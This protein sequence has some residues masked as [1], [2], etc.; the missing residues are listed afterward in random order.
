M[1]IL[2]A[3]DNRLFRRL[4]EVNL[5]AWGHEM[6]ICDDGEQAWQ[7]LKRSGGPRV[8]VLDWDM[9]KMQGVEVC[10]RLRSLKDHH[11]VYVILLTAKSGKAALLEGLDSGA[12]DYI[13]K[14][15]DPVELKVRL[16]AATR[17]VELQKDLLEAL[18][19]A[20]SRAKHDELTGIWNRS[21]VLEALEKELERS[22]RQSTT[23]GVVMVDIDHFKKINDDHGHVAGDRILRKIAISI[24]QSLRLYDSVGRYGGDE[25]LAILPNCGLPQAFKLAERVREGVS[26]NA[27]QLNGQ[28]IVC[29][30]SIGVAAVSKSEQVELS[31]VLRSADQALYEAKDRGRNCTAAQS[32]ASQELEVKSFEQGNRTNFLERLLHKNR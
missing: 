12:D 27:Y 20:E 21:A 15:Y 3:E 13:V 7:H 31:S 9:P 23:L 11:Y 4:L 30:V 5:V 29:T 32:L 6:V 16:R 25:F 17:I 24:S 22:K 14:P 10:R 2:V 28:P 18:G 8:A 19:R 1:K 26:A